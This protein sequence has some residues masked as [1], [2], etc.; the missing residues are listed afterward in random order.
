MLGVGRAAASRVPDRLGLGTRASPTRSRFRR[1]LTAFALVAA[2][3]AGAG[4]VSAQTYTPE[5]CQG[6]RDLRQFNI[7]H[8]DI[9]D[10]PLGRAQLADLNKNLQT[11]CG[12]TPG[13]DPPPSISPAPE[14]APDPPQPTVVA[15]PTPGPPADSQ[16]RNDACNLLTSSQTGAVIG[17]APS[18]DTPAALPGASGCEYRADGPGDQP[19][20]DVIYAQAD[21]DGLYATLLAGATQETST[22]TVSVPDVGDK[23]FTYMGQNGPGVVVLMANKVVVLE[24]SFTNPGHDALLTL[25]RQAAA[26][27][28]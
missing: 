11:F 20:L 19:Y 16:D 18:A 6:L 7:D 17:G 28:H 21:G 24:F 9:F 4:P 12:A 2:L 26:G 22:A 5:S 14:P 15:E 13:D 23:A 1:S 25:A 3:G 8:P 10:G 27:V